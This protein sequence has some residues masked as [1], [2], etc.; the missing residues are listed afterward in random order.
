MGMQFTFDKT[1]PTSFPFVATMISALIERQ[2]SGGAEL[3]IQTRVNMKDKF[4]QGTV[5]IPAGHILKFE[6]VYDALK[7]E[8]L[9]E[10]GLTITEIINDEQSAVASV[11]E[12]DAAFVFKPFMCQQ[13]L[14]G[15]GWSWIGFV[16]RCRAEGE[17]KE[18]AGETAKQQWIKLP[19]LKKMIDETPEKF[20]T[21][22]LPVLKY[23][24]EYI[25]K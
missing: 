22:Q 10:T 16:F 6:N 11:R 24:V 12:D 21:L 19:D 1:D 23:Y 4:Y 5:E 18:E 7:R 20:F 3:L 15:P 8:V 14:R 13:Y 25:E 9:E 2:G 17:L